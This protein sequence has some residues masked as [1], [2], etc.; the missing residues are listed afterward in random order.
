MSLLSHL[1]IPEEHTSFSLRA[2]LFIYRIKGI[3]YHPLISCVHAR[4]CGLSRKVET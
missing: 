2:I 1:L 3:I 4:P